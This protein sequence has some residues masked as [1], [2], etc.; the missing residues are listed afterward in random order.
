[1]AL[2]VIGVGVGRT[3]TF[4]MKLALEELG[5]GRCHH[6]EEVDVNSPEQ[7][8]LW[9]SAAD[10]KVDWNA[11]YAGFDS[12]VD[13][14]TAAFCQ[15]L[16]GAYPNAKFILTLR[17]P[18]KWYESFSNTIYAL[19]QPTEKTPRELL[20]FLD[21]VIAVVRKTGFQIPSTK[22]EILAAFH[23]HTETVK[24]TVPADRLLLFDVKQGWEPLCRFLGAPVPAKEFPRTNNTKDFWDSAQ[25]G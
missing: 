5:F 14:P 3:G 1:M 25:A 4:S 22:E 10:G 13:W 2:R 12:A 23:R 9:R 20:P 6:M 17:D 18:E 19:I 8:A 24:S 7:I 16:A 15:E 21:M 11:A